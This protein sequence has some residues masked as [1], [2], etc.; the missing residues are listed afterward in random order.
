MPTGIELRPIYYAQQLNGLLW[1]IIHLLKA[2]QPVSVEQLK[3]SSLC[4]HRDG[5]LKV[6]PNPCKNSLSDWCLIAFYE[7]MEGTDGKILNLGLKYE[8]IISFAETLISESPFDEELVDKYYREPSQINKN[9]DPY[10]TFTDYHVDHKQYMDIWWTEYAKI[11]TEVTLLCDNIGSEFGWSARFRG[12]LKDKILDEVFTLPHYMPER[13]HDFQKGCR[14]MVD[15][16]CEKGGLNAMSEYQKRVARISER[17]L[18]KFFADKSDLF[19]ESL[20][21]DLL[22]YIVAINIE[23]EFWTY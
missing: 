4:Y 13:L 14:R 11:R 17:Y 1:A 12:L 9:T 2:Y 7:F 3:N 22:L 20:I 6:S 18:R 15:E 5:M 21:E 8:K 16:L 23:Y 19:T 10:N